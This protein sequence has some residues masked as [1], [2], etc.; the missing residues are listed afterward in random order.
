[1]ESV[2]SRPSDDFPTDNLSSRGVEDKYGN[3]IVNTKGQFL[4]LLH[5]PMKGGLTGDE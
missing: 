3:D 1:M 5:K 2:S 4:P